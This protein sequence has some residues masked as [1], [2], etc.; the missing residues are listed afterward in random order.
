MSRRAWPKQPKVEPRWFCI[1]CWKY[2]EDGQMYC[3]GY[4]EAQDA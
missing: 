2:T 1:T 4:C 3:S